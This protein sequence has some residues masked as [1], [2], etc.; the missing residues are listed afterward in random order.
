MSIG[1]GRKGIF[2]Q[3]EHGHRPLAG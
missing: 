2:N 1:T 3:I